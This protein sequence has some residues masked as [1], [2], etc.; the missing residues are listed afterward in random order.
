MLEWKALSRWLVRQRSNGAVITSSLVP[1]NRITVYFTESIY[2]DYIL[3]PSHKK[4]I[5]TNGLTQTVMEQCVD[6]DSLWQILGVSFRNMYVISKWVNLIDI[7]DSALSSLLAPLGK[8]ID[9]WSGWIVREAELCWLSW[10]TFDFTQRRWAM[11]HVALG[12]WPEKH[13]YRRKIGPLSHIRWEWWVLTHQR[14]A[15]GRAWYY[16]LKY[17]EKSRKPL[18]L[19]REEKHGAWKLDFVSSSSP[20]DLQMKSDKKIHSC[21]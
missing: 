9:I 17:T 11:E 13:I 5:L 12:F 15:S 21:V 2:W 8:V 14:W 16:C 7:C 3:S 10:C 20:S 1:C 19:E 18:I 6:E 4:N